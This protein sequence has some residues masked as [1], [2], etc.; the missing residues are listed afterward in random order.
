[1]PSL[2]S[3]TAA[4][5][6]AGTLE[7]SVTFPFEYIKTQMQLQQEASALFAGKDR[8]RSPFHCAAATVRERGA[9]GL[10]RG[11][12]S[13]AL[14]G[15]PRSAV[16]FGTFETLT[17]A[18]QRRGMHQRL[19]TPT[20]DAINGFAAGM[21]EAALCQTPNQVIAIKM[22]HDQSPRGPCQ[23]EGLA[24]CVAC[25]W[26]AEGVGGFFQGVGPAVTKGAAT[27]AI[28]FLGF[29]Q[30]KRLAQ[31][32]AGADGAPPPPLATWQAMLCGGIAGAVS[33][34]A[35]QPIDTGTTRRQHWRG[36][37]QHSN[38]T[39]ELEQSRRT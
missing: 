7:I 25:I 21:A 5:W 37:T 38:P 8:F 35:T 18:S 33:A 9:L 14:F 32:P 1:M 6:V 29:G 19:G 31:G 15:G 13:W 26:R 36:H 34:V 11:G 20:A 39:C 30:L 12:L 24:H 27:N 10:Y 4:G 17:A 3:A 2:A 22:I 23:Y 16:R 28:R